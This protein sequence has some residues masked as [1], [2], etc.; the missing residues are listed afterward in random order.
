[1][2][3][4]RYLSLTLSRTPSSAVGRSRMSTYGPDLENEAL[5]I[6]ESDFIESCCTVA[7]C[8]LVLY[9]YSTTFSR[10]VELIWGRKRTSVTVLFHLNRCTVFVWAVL[11]AASFLSLATLPV[12]AM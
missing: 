5:A 3:I 10:E 1:M 4:H 11:Q 6:I 12:S 8:V 9:D 7:T 2:H